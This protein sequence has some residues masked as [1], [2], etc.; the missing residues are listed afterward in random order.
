MPVTLTHRPALARGSRK[1][2]GDDPADWGAVIQHPPRFYSE[3]GWDCLDRTLAVTRTQVDLML[4]PKDA[5]LCLRKAK[6][7]FVVMGLYG[8][9][10]WL[11]E[12]RTTED[13]DVLVPMKDVPKAVK[14]ICGEFPFLT[15]RDTPVVVRFEKDDKALLDIMKPHHPLF[16][17]AL[18]NSCQARL[19]GLAVQ[20]PVKEMALALKFFS[21]TSPGRQ[22]DD[23]YQ[24]AHDFINIAR[25]N[26]G[27]NPGKMREWG[28]LAFDGGGADILR[29]FE[30]AV[31][32]G[33]LEI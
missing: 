16:K 10:G 17:A 31:A 25:N 15:A 18:K 23:K 26:S 21:M 20:V 33:M 2:L 6:I 24:D 22:P 7:P 32:G 4:E 28:E 13:F 1:R 11:K 3:F 27:M 19:H 29:Q 8:I 14:A 12:P 5:I 9:S 30:H